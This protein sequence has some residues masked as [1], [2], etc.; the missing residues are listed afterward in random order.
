MQ[1]PFIA[2][3]PNLF[4]NSQ[5]PVRLI[6]LGGAGDVTKNMFVYESASDIVIIDCGI[7]FPDEVMPGIDLVIP[8]ITYLADKK[9]KIRA[10]LTTHAHEDHIGAL[11]YILP[12]LNVPVYATRLTAGFINAKLAE[13]KGRFQINTIKTGEVIKLG[14]FSAEFVG[15]SHSV[16]DAAN[17]I[18][19]TPVGVVYHGS[20][21]KFDWTPVSG[22]PTDV[23]RI[24]KAGSD[25]V[26]LL[27]SDC[28]RVEKT[29]TTLSE[30][31]IEETFDRALQ[32]TSGRCFIT[33]A[34]SNISR[35][36]QA[37]NSARK[38]GRKVS[39]LGRSIDK[40]VGVAKSLGYLKI[41]EGM[42]VASDAIGRNQNIVII[43]AGAQGQ[44]D[45]ALAQVASVAHRNVRLAEGDTIIFSADPIPGNEKAVHL[46]IDALS[47]LGANVLYSDILDNLHVSGHGA[48]DD[49]LLML[50]LTKPKF[51][52]PIGGTYH[53]MK[54]YSNLA[55]AAGF[56]KEQVFLTE[57]GQS[58]ELFP[59]Y[60]RRGPKFQ[61]RSIMVDN[62]GSTDINDAILRDRQAMSQEGLIVVIVPVDESTGQ[63][64]TDP[65]VIMRGFVTGA[66][67]DRLAKDIKTKIA[68]VLLT[69]QSNKVYDWAVLRRAV[70]DKVEAFV[71]N[72]SKRRPVI[73]PVIVE[74]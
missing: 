72:K 17:I 36:Q 63:L 43:I 53:H 5:P 48:Q 67:S 6:P 27:L 31:K 8:D 59:G 11:P 15:V 39:F 44:P 4:K 70:K 14:S 20:D 64:A 18:L 57:G 56:T 35:I 60:V 42:V 10:I 12:Q 73:L 24:A 49:L 52:L 55:Y 16:P 7:G 45:S 2:K 54:H 68:E 34:S 46:M 41:P 33:T 50:A 69:Y 26:L 13:V 32:K 61:A 1:N 66:E 28:L 74:V 51:V 23:Q 25:G 47:R 58:L 9:K 62:M 38:S 65:D 71:Y 21:F 3:R 22:E 37:I 19:R 40:A 30:R 29:G